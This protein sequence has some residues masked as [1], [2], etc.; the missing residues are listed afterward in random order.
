[1][2][3]ANSRKFYKGI[4]IPLHANQLF[5][6]L[7]S[8]THATNTKSMFGLLI[9]SQDSFW[10]SMPLVAYTWDASSIFA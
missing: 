7:S 6:S 4:T 10:V 9:I 3:T 2:D 1:M 8:L 5:L